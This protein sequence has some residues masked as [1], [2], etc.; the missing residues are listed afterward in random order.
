MSFYI[1]DAQFGMVNEWFG[2]CRFDGEA[3][4][5]LTRCCVVRAVG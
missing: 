2:A 5:K 4:A 3:E 1:L